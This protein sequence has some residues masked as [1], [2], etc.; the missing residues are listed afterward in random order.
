M[1]GFSFNIGQVFQAALLVSKSQS[2]KLQATDFIKCIPDLLTLLCP[3]GDKVI[4][5]SS[6]TGSKSESM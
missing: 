5:V 4:E 3:D 2:S 6:I 1:K